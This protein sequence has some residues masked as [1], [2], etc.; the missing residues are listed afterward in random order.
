MKNIFFIFSLLLIVSCKEQEK[1]E[2]KTE[3]SQG[4]E[5]AVNYA[6]GFSITNYE[7]YKIVKVSSPWPKAE[8]DFTYVLAEKGVKLPKELSYNERVTIP[9]EKMVVTSTT[10][11]PSL[12]SLGVE[13]TL[14]GFPN[15]QYVSSKKTRAL[16]DAGKVK[17]LGKNEAINTEVLLD[18]L[19][20]VVIGFA[21]ESG[22]KTFNT[23]QKSGI[24]V[25]YNG[26]WVEA[27]PL[28]K[29]EWIKFFGAFYNKEQ[30]AS[31]LFN[32]IETSYN[33]AKKLAANAKQQPSVLCGSMYKDVWYLPYGDSW[34]AKFIKDANANYLYKD[35]QGS[36]SISMA[37]ESVLE[38]AQNADFWIAP[39]AFTSYQAM[40]NSSEHYAKFKAFQHKKIYSFAGVKGDTGG[41]LYYELA[42]NRPDLVL[43]DLIKIFHPE[44]LIDY[45]STFFK[46][47][48]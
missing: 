44:L 15:T 23:I 30:M 16:I 24:P 12:E 33:E 36:G 40:S 32:D 45:E 11:I 8:E 43:K 20:D 10:H 42:P 34:Q 25:V 22:N 6:K 39:G 17:E 46:T 27:N 1:K 38:N 29:A 19:P 31:S 21:M 47:L 3:V 18:I 14:V 26:D 13:H 28:G 5:V 7:N 37:F 9:V 2:V 35:T 4:E 48:D 41:V